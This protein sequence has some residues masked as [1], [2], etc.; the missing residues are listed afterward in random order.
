MKRLFIKV[1]ALIAILIASDIAEASYDVSFEG[2]TVIVKTDFRTYYVDVTSELMKNDVVGILKRVCE[3]VPE[4]CA[5][6]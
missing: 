2:Y 4:T 6:K 5:K 1:I 3:K